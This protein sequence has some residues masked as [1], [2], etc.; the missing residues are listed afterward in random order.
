MAAKIP[1]IET[2]S[3]EVQALLDVINTKGETGKGIRGR[4]TDTPY[5][6]H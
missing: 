4:S 6:R 3:K 5:F 2:L 1:A